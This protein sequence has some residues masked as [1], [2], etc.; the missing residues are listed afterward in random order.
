[1]P[2]EPVMTRFLAEQLST[3][4]W[5]DISAAKRDFGYAPRVGFEEGLRRLK[6]AWE[7]RPHE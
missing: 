5:Y 2:G 1:L 4:H 6:A 7:S 3:T